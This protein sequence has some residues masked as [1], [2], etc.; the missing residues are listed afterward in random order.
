MTRLT[1]E[2]LTLRPHHLEDVEALE[3]IYG[4]AEV[5]RYLTD[6]PWDSVLAH[7]TVVGRLAKVSLGSPAGALAL[8]AEFG[9]EVVGSVSIWWTDRDAR[10]AEIGWVFD[11]AHGGRGLATEAAA[12]VIRQ[13]FSRYHVR[14][15]VAQMD[16]RNLGSARVAER[17]GMTREAHLRRDW[18]NKGEWT[19]TIV[20][21]LLDSDP[22]PQPGP[23]AVR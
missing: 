1:A 10:T 4:Q 5:A 13:G 15:L 3:R 16:A 14:R 21:S 17:L 12:A 20:Y 11:P 8:V 22:L 9:D 7:S 6:P 19:D 23:L 2:R 18:W